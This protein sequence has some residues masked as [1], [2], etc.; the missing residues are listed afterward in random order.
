[1]PKV[2]GYQAPS[3]LTLAKRKAAFV[4]TK[5]DLDLQKQLQ[6]LNK[7]IKLLKIEQRA[8]VKAMKNKTM[9]RNKDKLRPVCLYALKLEDGCYYVGMSFNV[10]RRFVKHKNGKGA[11]WTRLHRPIEIVESRQTEFY[12]QD[13]VALMEND[14]TFE[15]AMRFGKDYVRG[16]GYCQMKPHWPDVVTQNEL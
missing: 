10:D 16:G 9:L 8:V 2:P 4:F 6:R 15:Y 7:Q 3:P 14:M 11:T 12:D 5:T 13:E 1:M